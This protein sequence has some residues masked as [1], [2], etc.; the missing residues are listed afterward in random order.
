[1]AKEAT[2][3]GGEADHLAKSRRR[4]SVGKSPA[5][6]AVVV[7]G[8]PAGSCKPRRLP[9]RRQRKPE[10]PGGIMP[11]S[12]GRPMKR[13]LALS[14]VLLAVVTKAT[15]EPK[16]PAPFSA[17]QPGERLPAGWIVTALPNIPRAT[18]FDLVRDGEATVLRAVSESAAA[19]ASYRLTADPSFA[20]RLSWRW[21]VSR[22]LGKADLATKDGDDYAAR[23]Y[24]FFD[25]DVARLP[26]LER[27]KIALA[28]AL[29][30]ADL[31]AA[32]LCYVW[33]NRYPVGTSTWSA[34]TNRVRM[35]V[36]Q[37]G[38]AKVGQWVSETRDA[39]GD[40]RAAFGEEPPAISGIALAAD[41]DNTGETVVS[42]FGDVILGVPVGRSEAARP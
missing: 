32:T 1:M 37:S 10:M 28:R 4:G 24:V 5:R 38:P 27:S 9:E 13:S 19:S 26:F 25:Y 40:F 41:T 15:A 33:D 3:A 22:M 16:Q 17:A 42:H 30:G 31:P 7:H 2:E 21:K 36:L 20:S 29:Y 18:R 14:V 8:R 12:G 34:Y 11:I 6:G 39:A 23:V 35:I